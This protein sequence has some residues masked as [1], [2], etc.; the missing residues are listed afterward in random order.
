MIASPDEV[1]PNV[2]FDA[3]E[4]RTRANLR[5]PAVAATEM[6]I[7]IWCSWSR[8]SAGVSHS[9]WLW[10][11]RGRDACECR[12][13]KRRSGRG[14]LPVW[15]ESEGCVGRFADLPRGTLE[16]TIAV[17]DPDVAPLPPYYFRLE[18]L[19]GDAILVRWDTP[20]FELQL[21]PDTYSVWV[22]ETFAHEARRGPYGQWLAVRD[23]VVGP[24]QA[25]SVLAAA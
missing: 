12:G 15:G 25:T 6:A 9:P 19:S 13:G 5:K 8:C 22:M 3:H 17:T 20:S 24:D 18:A 21:P 10:E 7:S 23:L 14:Q 4:P 2:E 11:H 16:V 1:A